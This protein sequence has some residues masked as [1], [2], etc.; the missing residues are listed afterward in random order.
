[1]KLTLGSLASAGECQLA[2]TQGETRSRPLAVT[3]A[4]EN[5]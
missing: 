3:Q 1:M 4:S 2:A 5:F